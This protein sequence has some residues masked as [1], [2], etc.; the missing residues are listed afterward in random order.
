[1]NMKKIVPCLLVMLMCLSGCAP[2][3]HMDQ[4]SVIGD[5]AREKNSQG[6]LVQ[7]IDDHYDALTKAI[8]QGG[9]GYYKY[10]ALFLNTF[11]DPILKK[12]LPDGS[13]QWLYRYAIFSRA[14][15]KVYVYFDNQ[16]HLIKWEK[17][18]CPSL[19]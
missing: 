2:L 4:L 10:K 12:D 9:M 17:V 8:A 7:S 13:Q 3:E 18:P 5:Y 15:D 14:H 16:D 1:M 6:R 11:G 19:F